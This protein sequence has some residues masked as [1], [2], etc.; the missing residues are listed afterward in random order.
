MPRQPALP[1]PL[2]LKALLGSAGRAK[3]LAHFLLHPGEAFH[4]R[5][6]ARLLD[7]SPGSLLRDLRRLETIRLLHVNRVGNQVRYSM[8]QKHRSTPNCNVSFS[9]LPQRMLCSA[10]RCSRCVVSN[11]PC[12]KARSP[13]ERRPAGERMAHNIAY[14][15]MLL[16]GRAVM[17]SE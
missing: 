2:A 7:G 1:V 8:E 11:W 12:S 3:L 5:E 9:R 6:L 4:T 10:R 17:F 13:K 15:A 14:N 16:A